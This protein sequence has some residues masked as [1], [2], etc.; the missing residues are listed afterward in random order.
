[1]H[2]NGGGVWGGYGPQFVCY[3]FTQSSKWH[4]ENTIEI[5]LTRAVHHLRPRRVYGWIMWVHMGR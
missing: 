4:S 2:L 5:V 1:M 3:L